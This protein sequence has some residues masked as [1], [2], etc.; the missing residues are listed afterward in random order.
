MNPSYFDVNY[1]GTRFWHTANKVIQVTET[2]G[3]KKAET[4]GAEFRIDRIG[5]SIIV[6]ALFSTSNIIQQRHS[7]L[8]LGCYLAVTAIRM[9]KQKKE[10]TKITCDNTSLMEQIV[11][12]GSFLSRLSAAQDLGLLVIWRHKWYWCF[13]FGP[14]S[15]G[16]FFEDLKLSNP[17][18]S[19]YGINIYIYICIYANL[20]GILMVNVIICYHIQHTWILWEMMLGKTVLR[21]QLHSPN[22]WILH[23]QWIQIQIVQNLQIPRKRRQF[24]IQQA[25][26]RCSWTL[27]WTRASPM[28][29]ARITSM[30]RWC[31]WMFITNRLR[32]S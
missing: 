3:K 12:M 16:W 21:I 17:I 25:I 10:L 23:P 7:W 13:P 30:E 32:I 5:R 18:G 31:W 9:E 14:T 26:H 15:G 11:S 6:P 29:E 19:M 24:H 1:R 22:L 28:L 2:L 20:G 4:T 27:H 8:P